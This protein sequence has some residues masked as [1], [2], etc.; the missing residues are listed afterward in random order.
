[1]SAHF[2]TSYLWQHAGNQFASTMTA[3]M[4]NT[5]TAGTVD[6]LKHSLLEALYFCRIIPTGMRFAVTSA[7]GARWL[8]KWNSFAMKSSPSEP[9]QLSGKLNIDCPA[10]TSWCIQLPYPASVEALVSTGTLQISAAGKT[11]QVTAGQRIT[12]SHARTIFIYGIGE[13]DSGLA[14]SKFPSGNARLLKIPTG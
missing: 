6:A 12:L 1:M 9:D 10:W 11:E 3:D 7:R 2:T 8:H 14:L 13:Q 5:A 4:D